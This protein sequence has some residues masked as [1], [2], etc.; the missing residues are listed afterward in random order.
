MVLMQQILELQKDL[1]FPRPDPKDHDRQ[2]TRSWFPRSKRGV[3]IAID[4]NAMINSFF[5]GIDS[6]FHLHSNNEVRKGLRNQ[7]KRLDKLSQFTVTYARKTTSL[8]QHLASQ[9]NDLETQFQ[10]CY[11]RPCPNHGVHQ[12]GFRC[13][14]R[15]HR[16]LPRHHTLNCHDIIRSLIHP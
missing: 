7:T 3:D 12:D 5:S 2:R 14:R 4:G 16:P 15:P 8:L 13:T 1:K 10:A 11:H 9:V 6:I